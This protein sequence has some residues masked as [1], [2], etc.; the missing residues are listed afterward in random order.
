KSQLLKMV[1]RQTNQVT[2]P[3][4]GDL[5]RLADPPGGVS[6][7][8]GAMADV[9]TV[10]GLHQAANCF[11]EKVGITQSMV[12]EPF[13]QV[14]RQTD[15]GGSQA[16]FAVDVTIMDTTNSQHAPCIPVAIIANELRH[17]PGFQRWPVGPQPG[18]IP[19][20]GAHQLTLAFPEACQQFA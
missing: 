7:Q 5:Q 12:P 9:E 15:V 10:N 13:G 8:P 2:L 18:K 11:L 17:G 16:V 20:Q 19:N 1:W 14:G 6:G 4:H 3:G